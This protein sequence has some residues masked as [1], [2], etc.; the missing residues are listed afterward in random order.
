[1]LKNLNVKNS[2]NPVLS[3]IIPT[4]NRIQNLKAII[5]CLASQIDDR[6]KIIILDNSS[7]EYSKKH[8]DIFMSSLN[9]NYELIRNKINIGADANIMRCFEICETEWMFPLGD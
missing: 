9:I 4:R 5:L 3:I 8:L 7:D 6:C 2:L 1:M